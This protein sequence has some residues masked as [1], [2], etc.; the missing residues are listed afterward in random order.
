MTRRDPRTTPN[1][2]LFADRMS[3][4]EKALC[5]CPDHAG[6]VHVDGNRGHSPGCPAHPRNLPHSLTHCVACDLPFRE[7]L[8]GCDPYAEYACEGVC[9]V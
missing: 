2:S 6:N 9:D 4:V 7:P 3:D 1:S 8:F 5:E